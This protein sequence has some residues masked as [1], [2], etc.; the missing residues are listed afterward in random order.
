MPQL[1]YSSDLAPSDFYLFP[2]VKEKLQ[3]IAM[4]DQDQIFEYSIEILAGLDHTELNRVFHGWKERAQQV[5][6]GTGYYIG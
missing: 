1:P 6:E 3:H 5:S 2:T 4:R